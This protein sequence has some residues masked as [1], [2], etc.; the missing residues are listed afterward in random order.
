MCIRDRPETQQRLLNLMRVQGMVEAKQKVLSA[1]GGQL[2]ADQWQLQVQERLQRPL[3][4]SGVRV[5]SPVWA[6]AVQE[7]L[8]MEAVVLD[9]ERW[10]GSLRGP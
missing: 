6:A 10:S 9:L 1:L 5:A 2:S 4:Q 3:F 8:P 7:A